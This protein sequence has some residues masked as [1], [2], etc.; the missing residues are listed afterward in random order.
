MSAAPGVAEAAWTRT[1]VVEWNEPALYY[2]GKDGG[3][4]EP[5]SD[6]PKGANPDPD[7][8]AVLVKAGYAPAEARALLDLESRTLTRDQQFNQ[9]AF[10]GR[11]RANV[12]AD[13][14][15]TPDPGFVEVT[16]QVGEGIDLDG[17]RRTGFTS[18]SGERGV[19]NAFYR[20]MGCWKYYRGPPRTSATLVAANDNARNGAWTVVIVVS[21]SGPDPLN[22][23]QVRLGV[24]LSADRLAKNSGGEA[25]R[26]YT[27]RIRPHRAYEALFTGRTS[28]GRITTDAT[29]RVVVRDAAFGQ[30][31]ELLNARAQLRM[32]PDGRLSGYLGG[33]RPWATLYDEFMKHRGAV[34]EYFAGIQMPQLWYAFRRNADFS[35]TGP[36]GPK[37]HI[38]YALRIDALP[39]YVTEPDGGALVTGARSYRDVA[40][41]DEPPLTY[42]TRPTAYRVVDGLSA[43]PGEPPAPPLT[44]DM[45]RQA[46]QSNARAQAGAGGTP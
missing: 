10:R 19:D 22:D 23:D 28:G 37:T 31:L 30:G 1:Y 46:V 38:S 7:W 15:S 9:M 21:G 35:P 34:F 27:F 5:G 29:D 39:A 11:N 42:P 13:P 32:L 43:R 2:G 14:A 20:A 44:A 26:D 8:T 4:V 18:P 16:G 45:L 17:D 36:G 24:Y 25:Q 3:A 6:C 40:P 12:F 41:P 33:Y